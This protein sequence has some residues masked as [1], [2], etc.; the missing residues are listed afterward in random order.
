MNG[1]PLVVPATVLH[2]SSSGSHSVATLE[3]I[4]AWIITGLPDV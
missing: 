2:F 1:R 4:R 3:D